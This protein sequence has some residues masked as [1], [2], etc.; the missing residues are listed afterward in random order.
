MNRILALLLLFLANVAP[1]AA[2]ITYR[3]TPS[4]SAY[5]RVRT[6]ANTSFAVAITEESSG[7]VGFYRVSDAA[8]LSA[9]GGTLAANISPGYYFTVFAGSA[10]TTANDTILATGV[11]GWN[12]TAERP[13]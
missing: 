8:I 7:G 10:S 12:G 4:I 13:V 2:E 5:A 6:A 1:C 9:A 3:G 11:L